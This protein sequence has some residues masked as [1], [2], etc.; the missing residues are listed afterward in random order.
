MEELIGKNLAG[1]RVEVWTE[2]SNIRENGE[3]KPSMY[4]TNAERDLLSVI[5]KGA[6][7]GCDASP[8]EVY[9]LTKDGKTGF[10]IKSRQVELV[11]PEIARTIAMEKIAGKLS[12]AEKRI[13]SIE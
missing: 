12:D 5:M 11:D 7:P 1:W 2:L 6:G 10:I 8:A 13:L 9:V 4:F 3:N